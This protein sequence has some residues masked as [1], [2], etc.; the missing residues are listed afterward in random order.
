[1]KVIMKQPLSGPAFNYAKGDIVE[2]DE[3]ARWIEHGIAIEFI[4]PVIETATASPIIERASISRKRK[5]SAEVASEALVKL[6]DAL[7][8]TDTSEG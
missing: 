3:G 1:M 7:G 8:D 4:E 2:T 5:P 6:A